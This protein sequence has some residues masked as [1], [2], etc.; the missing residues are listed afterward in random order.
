MLP[1]T[2]EKELMPKIQSKQPEKLRPYLFHG[3]DLTWKDG[4]TQAVGECPFC[5][6]EGHFIVSIETG[7]WDCKVC[8]ESGNHYVF[9][10]KLWTKS[11]EETTDYLVLQESRG[12]ESS[13]TLMSWGVARSITTGDWLVPGYG[14]TGKLSQLY[15]YITFEKRSLLMLTPTLGHRL[16]GV[17]LYDKNKSS[18]FLCEGPWDAMALWEMLSCAKGTHDGLR[19]TANRKQSLL[20]DRNVLAVP[21]CTVFEKSWLPLFSGKKVFL[22]FD[23]DHPRKHPKT[24]KLV[25]PGGWSGM[26]RVTGMLSSAENPPAS[27]GCVTWGKEGF[28][29]ILP[30]GYDLKDKLT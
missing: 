10:K 15:R 30:S 26:E 3:I 17:N 29:P 12:L 21:T 22:M 9:L 8:G 16:H 18:V 1:T 28:C 2:G 14:A 7:Q 24:G 27:I 6:K 20:A 25:K 4:D 13:S 5:G 11:F 23:N 19:A